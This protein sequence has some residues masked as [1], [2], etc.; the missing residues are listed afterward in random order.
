M[1]A[2]ARK[3]PLAGFEIEFGDLHFLARQQVVDLLVQEGKVHGVEGFKV[4]FPVFVFGGVFP[5]QEVIVQLNDLGI[6][7]Q[8]PALV[9]ESQR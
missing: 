2:V 9:G 5:V 1:H 3:G 7:A 8:D 4:V 6:Q